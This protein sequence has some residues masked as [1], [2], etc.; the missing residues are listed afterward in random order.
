MGLFYSLVEVV[1]NVSLLVP[2]GF[3][4]DSAQQLPGYIYHKAS[5]NKEESLKRTLH[6]VIASMNEG[7]R[8]NISRVGNS[9]I[10]FD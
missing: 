2:Q 7:K 9:N 6:P 4:A 8:R 3:R 1:I 10:S 5:M